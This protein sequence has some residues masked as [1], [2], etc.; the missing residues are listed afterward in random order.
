M[1]IREGELV[2]EIEVQDIFADFEWN[3]RDKDSLDVSDL[4]RAIRQN[5]QEPLLTG[6][7]K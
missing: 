2:Y 1:S 5:G 7:G 6:S 4:Q 3:I